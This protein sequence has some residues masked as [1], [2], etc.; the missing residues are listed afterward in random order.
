MMR[1]GRD[2][3]AWSGTF[4]MQVMQ[5][6]AQKPEVG[7]KILAFLH[8]KPTPWPR[9]LNCPVLGVKRSACRQETKRAL[10]KNEKNKNPFDFIITKH[11]TNKNLFLLLFFYNNFLSVC[12]LPFDRFDFERR[13]NTSL[14][15]ALHQHTCRQVFDLLLS[16]FTFTS[17]LSPFA[18]GSETQVNTH[19]RRIAPRGL[20][21]HP[22]V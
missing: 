22:F 9:A 8:V 10:G 3:V 1:F 5:V 12:N 4:K 7:P 18:R 6:Q 16:S 13:S 11:E 17:H 21:F 14:A 2:I 15:C 19:S 20:S